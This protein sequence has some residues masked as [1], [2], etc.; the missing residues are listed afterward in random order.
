MKKIYRNAVAFL[1]II[2]TALC[3]TACGTQELSFGKEVFFG[4]KAAEEMVF[5]KEEERPVQIAVGKSRVWTLTANSRD[6]VYEREIDT[7]AVR[8]LEWQKGEQELVMGIAAVDDTLYAGVSC[9]E[10]V[11]VRRFDGDGQCETLISIPW[12]DGPEQIQPTLFFVDRAG[13]AYFAKED[14]IWQYSPE[15]GQR[16]I[17]K[18]KEPA[19]FLQEKSQGTVEAVTKSSREV[20]LY[21]LM[22]GGEAGKRWSIKLSAGHLAAVQT[23]SADTLALAA[24]GRILFVDNATGKIASHFDSIAAGVSANLLGGLWLIEE[25]SM[26]LAANLMHYTIAELVTEEAN[27]Y[28]QGDRTAEEAAGNI[29]NRVQLMLGE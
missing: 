6:C 22:E 26:Y 8:K 9:G 17:Y 7:G 11:Q 20:A 12:G 25:G 14:E 18:L 19:V 29:Q 10:T 13:N 15:N 24:D 4:V 21:T 3:Y 2:L 16:T 1:G 23:D 27:A 28:F 5:T